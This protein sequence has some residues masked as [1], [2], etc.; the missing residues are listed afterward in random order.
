MRPLHLGIIVGT[1]VRPYESVPSQMPAQPG[2]QQ[3]LISLFV[4]FFVHGIR[5]CTKPFEALV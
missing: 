5:K 3:L 4:C 2:L 1:E